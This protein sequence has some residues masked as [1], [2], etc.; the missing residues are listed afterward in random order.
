MISDYQTNQNYLQKQYNVVFESNQ[1]YYNLLKEAG[2]SW[3]KTPKNH[4]ARNDE[5]VKA[6]KKEIEEMWVK[7]PPEIEA[8]SLR[9]FMIDQCNL[10]AGRSLRRWLGNN[11]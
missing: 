2:V 11:R 8:G 5:L 6:K 3:K 7:W 4:P 1:S 10:R 9:V